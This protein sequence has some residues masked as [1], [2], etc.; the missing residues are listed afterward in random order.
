MGLRMMKAA[1]D[2]TDHDDP[3]FI[4]ARAYVVVVTLDKCR[5]RLE[6]QMSNASS[7]WKD[8]LTA[9]TKAYR[10]ILRDGDN[11]ATDK[12]KS[13]AFDEVQRLVAERD[14]ISEE[15]AEDMKARK[16]KISLVDEADAEAK[17]YK[18]GD[19]DQ[20]A[21]FADEAKVAGMPW[22]TDKALGV[23]YTAL[24]D[25][26]GSGAQLDDY[27]SA[28]MMEL[29]EAQVEGADLGLEA[30]QAIADEGA[31]EFTAG[32]AGISDVDDEDEEE[33]F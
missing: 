1:N 9:S 33:L 30:A 31:E 14:K 15:K 25:L 17:A 12:V 6:A 8:K 32:E 28:L 16:A 29:A 4:R 3:T 2:P 13:K 23:I 19:Q 18:S 24:Q 5:S 10:E 22:A 20:T 26:D 11:K 27:Q 7:V 21:L